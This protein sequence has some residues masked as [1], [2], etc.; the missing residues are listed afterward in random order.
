MVAPPLAE[1]GQPQ[2]DQNHQDQY[3]AQR[4]LH[5]GLL[6]KGDELGF[7]VQQFGALHRGDGHQVQGAVDL[8]LVGQLHGAQDL[9]L[10]NGGLHLIGEEGDLR[11]DLVQIQVLGEGPGDGA[12]GLDHDLVGLAGEGDGHLGHRLAALGDGHPL[13]VGEAPFQQL[14]ALGELTLAKLFIARLFDGTGPQHHRDQE[15]V[16]VLRRRHQAPARLV[17]GA[18]FAADTLVIDIA[19]VVQV[20][21]QAVGVVVETLPGEVGGRDRVAGGSDDGAEQVVFQRRGHEQGDVVGGGVVVLVVEAVGVGEV[22][23]LAAQL[24]GFPVHVGHK[25]LHAAVHR[26][27]QSLGRVVGGGEEEAVEQFLHR[28]LFPGFQVGA[29]LV[30]EGFPGGQLADGDHGVLCQLARLQGLHHQQGG[31][32]LGDAGGVGIVV[33]VHIVQYLAVVGVHQHRV[34]ALELRCLQGGG[35][36]AQDGQD[37]GD[38]KQNGKNTIFFHR[39]ISVCMVY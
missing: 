22:G 37:H 15:S 16:A 27:G 36:Q 24:P 26:L 25:L 6:E 39:K 30:R 17:G 31:H 11:L 29:G 1:D 34:A 2:N 21:N 38:D 3:Q 12:L 9:P 23:A 33:G 5:P 10:L 19:H 18:R 8:P 28:Q 35:G 20:G 14:G 13:K 32:H 7:L 4:Q